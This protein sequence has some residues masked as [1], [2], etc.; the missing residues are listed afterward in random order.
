MTEEDPTQLTCAVT[1]NV[2]NWTTSILV[3]GS[4]IIALKI[5]VFIVNVPDAFSLMNGLIAKISPSSRE[6][7]AAPSRISSV[8][9][10][11]ISP[12]LDEVPIVIED[13]PPKMLILADEG[14]LISEGGFRLPRRT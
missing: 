10:L 1:V 4:R 14:I 8:P 3:K 13:A 11:S 9:S 6:R 12:A 5:V 2:L 7:P